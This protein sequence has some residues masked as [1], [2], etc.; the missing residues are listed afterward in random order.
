MSSCFSSVPN[1]K[2]KDDIKPVQK[3]SEV[4]SSLKPVILHYKKGYRSARR[5]TDLGW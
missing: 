1:E 5:L 4:I 3:A 2:D